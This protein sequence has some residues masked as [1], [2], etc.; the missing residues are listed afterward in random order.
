VTLLGSAV[1]ASE[2][3]CQSAGKLRLYGGGSAEDDEEKYLIPLLV[4]AVSV[5]AIK[6]LKGGVKDNE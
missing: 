3:R 6:S 2:E 5:S 1:E 4:T